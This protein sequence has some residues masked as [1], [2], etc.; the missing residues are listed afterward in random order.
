MSSLTTEQIQ[1]ALPTLQKW[2]LKDDKRIE[3]KY[4]FKEFLQAI[5]FVNEIAQLSEEMNHHPFITIQYKIV[6]VSLTSW[7]A[8][9]LT[10][11][12]FEMA[13]EFEKIFS[14]MTSHF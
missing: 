2:S 4:V 12:D 10:Q 14:R 3:R 6:L 7:S 11:T 9:G 8:K 1:Q 5:S 13:A